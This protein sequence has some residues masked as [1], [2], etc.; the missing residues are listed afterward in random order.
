MDISALLTLVEEFVRKQGW[1]YWV[2]AALT[3]VAAI[4]FSPSIDRKLNLIDLHY[5]LFQKISLLAPRPPQPR[6]IMVVSIDDQEHQEAQAGAVG[7]INRSYL[8]KL[9]AA[10]DAANVSVIALD[11]ELHLPSP[12][13]RGAYSE[14]PEAERQGLNDLVG[15]LT[16]AARRRSIVLPKML[17]PKTYTFRAD[18]LGPFGL[19]AS[20]DSNHL[21]NNPGSVT[22]KVT[23]SKEQQSNI[24][25]GFI[26][27]PK[28]KWLVPPILL[29]DQ[30]Q[31]SDSFSLALVRAWSPELAHAIGTNL[32]YTDYIAPAQMNQVVVSASDV[33]R[34]DPKTLKRLRF[35]PVIIGG[36]WND[37]FG[38]Q[39]DMHSTPVGPLS[40]MLIHANYAESILDG[41]LY[42]GLGHT[43]L[44]LIE[45]LLGAIAAVVFAL[46]SSLWWKF[47]AMFG[48]A[49]TALLI[50]WLMFITVGTFIDALVPVVGLAVHSMLERFFQAEH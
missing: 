45:F 16:S 12:N 48:L 21:W 9:V 42:P 2:T 18:E 40:G 22:Q 29:D 20:I 30:G 46:R 13:A 8:A 34:G 27:L 14:I 15:S 36:A 1:R 50:Q 6:F 4:Y 5:R 25:C 3:L 19:C 26:S 31:E 37:A 7:P 17:I 28:R 33:L 41:R 23:L 39:V 44:L 43:T 49:A 32:L 10:L 24:Y 47:S 11:F 35:K 38:D